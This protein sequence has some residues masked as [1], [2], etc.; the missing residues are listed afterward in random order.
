MALANLKI[1]LEVAKDNPTIYLAVGNMY[2]F[3]LSDTTKTMEERELA[4]VEAENA[5]KQ[6]VELKP[7]YFDAMYNL[8][9][10]YFNRGANILLAAD[11]LP[12]G[13][14]KYDVEKVK[15]D[16]YLK[17]ALPYLES[18]RVIEPENYET[19]FSLRQIYSRSG[20]LEK[21][22]EVDEKMKSL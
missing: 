21:W 4:F 18:A 20:D 17:I 13:D 12:L 22:K 6:A 8:G 5:Y 10:L 15:G 9:A 11:E 3:I 14:P 2:D 19:L 16:N 1:A 7:D